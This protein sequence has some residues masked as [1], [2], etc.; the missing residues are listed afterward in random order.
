[1]KRLLVVNA[2]FRGKEGRNY[3]YPAYFIQGLKQALAEDLQIDELIL[4][5]HRL[6]APC[7]GDINSCMSPENGGYCF[8]Y[9]EINKDLDLWKQ[10]DF[11]VWELSHGGPGGL[12]SL[13]KAFLEKCSILTSLRTRSIRE[14]NKY[15]SRVDFSNQ[16]H[17]IFCKAGFNVDAE[18]SSQEQINNLKSFLEIVQVKDIQS[19][20]YESFNI[21]NIEKINQAFFE[22]GLNWNTDDPFSDLKALKLPSDQAYE[23]FW[24]NHK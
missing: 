11:V 16:K 7:C 3:K 2:S 14:T 10:A 5:G 22:A 21:L 18:D 6:T 12:N 17:F 19:F 9:P 24:I 20:W 1:M 4:T 13:I 15:S 8:C 23:K